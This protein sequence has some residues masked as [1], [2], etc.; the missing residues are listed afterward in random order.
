VENEKL[1]LTPFSL[2][3]LLNLR[4][5]LMHYIPVLDNDDTETLREESFVPHISL[6][7]KI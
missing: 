1:V 7:V 3:K 4:R 6:V 2:Q 5:Y